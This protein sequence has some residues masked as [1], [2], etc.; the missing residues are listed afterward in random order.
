MKSLR[1]GVI[2]CGSISQ[3]VHIPAYVENPKSRLTAICDVNEQRLR[4]VAKEYEIANIFH[5]YEELLESQLVDA[6]SICTPTATHW[7]IAVEAARHG[8]HTLC[9][10][11]LASNL[12]EGQAIINAVNQSKIKFMVG[13]NYRFLPNHIMTK[14]F[15]DAGRIGIPLFIRGELVDLGPYETAMD[16]NDYCSEAKKR[17]GAFLDLGS[18]FV[19]LFLWMVGKPKEVF[20]MFSTHTN[21]S[22]IDDLAT[23][24]IM[25]QSNVI[26]SIT[27]SWV[28][29]PDFQSMMDSRIIEIVGT[30]GKIDSE[31]YGP[32]LFFYSSNSVSSKIRGKVRI[33]PV[34]F[35]SKIPDEALKWSYKSEIDSFVESILND[36]KPPIPIEHGFQVL[37][38]VTAAYE[39]AR[40]N[41]SINLE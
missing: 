32:S 14:R 1:I 16:E 10:K 9:E 23:V 22:N 20:G 18:H 4:E 40:Q 12:E 21:N 17:I 36:K 35:H 11:P 30:K 26:G 29:L 7:K 8:I 5:N 31:F 34:R 27:V 13:F 6:V 24:L 39:S 28:N 41:S 19:D 2:G 37:R 38:L 25:F 33:M 15:I 3:N